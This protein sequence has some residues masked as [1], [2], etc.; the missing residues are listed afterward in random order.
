MGLREVCNVQAFL[1]SVLVIERQSS[2]GS[3]PAKLLV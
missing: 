1:M 3:H 2:T